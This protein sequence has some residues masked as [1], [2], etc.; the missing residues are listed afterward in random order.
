MSTNVLDD[1]SLSVFQRQVAHGP[2]DPDDP[3][4]VPDGAP[5]TAG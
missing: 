5:L 4:S 2:D 1:L 3:A